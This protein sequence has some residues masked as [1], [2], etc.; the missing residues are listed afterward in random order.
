MIVLYLIFRYMKERCHG[1]QIMLE[2]T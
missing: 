1:N 2:E